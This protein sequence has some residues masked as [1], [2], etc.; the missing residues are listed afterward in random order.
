MSGQPSIVPSTPAAVAAEI[1]ASLRAHGNPDNVAG[2]ARYGISA[3]GTLGVSVPT[4]RAMARDAKKRLG[5]DPLAHHELAAAL[6]AS[7]VH[8]ARLMATLVDAPALVGEDQM[9]AWANDLD[10]W[11]I[12]D[13]L[14]SNLLRRTALAWQKAA[15]WPS[16]DEQFVKRAGFVLGATLAVHDKSAADARFLPLLALAEREATDERNF[17]KKAVNW[18]VR[19]VGK[20]SATLNETA[21]SSCVRILAEHPESRSARWVARDALRELRSEAVRQRLST[22]R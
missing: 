7:G 4:V 14:C 18:Q 3:A 9:E 2:M 11:D 10:S 19:Q 20:R 5:R 22:A 12:C 16:R 8:E 17:V 13:G 15:E 21:I 1:L 6:W